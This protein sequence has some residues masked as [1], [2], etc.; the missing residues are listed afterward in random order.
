LQVQIPV[1]VLQVPLD[2]QLLG[3]AILVEVLVDELDDE[4]EPLYNG[5]GGTY[6]IFPITAAHAS[7]AV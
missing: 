4:E 2:E 6:V 7:T 3:Q 1:A 5:A